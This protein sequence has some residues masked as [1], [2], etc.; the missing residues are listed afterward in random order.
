MPDRKINLLPN[1]KP[2][3]GDN[4]HKRP[5]KMPRETFEMYVPDED[6]DETSPPVDGLKL[7]TGKENTEKS[8]NLT[9]KEELSSIKVGSH[10]ISF[11]GKL[12]SIFNFKK[13]D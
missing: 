5:N 8:T 4:S 9:S 7:E 12:K 10:K 11:L 6:D 1:S 3:T 2:A 13:E